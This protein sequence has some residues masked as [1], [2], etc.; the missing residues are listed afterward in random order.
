MVQPECS[1]L[2]DTLERSSCNPEIAII[3]L[4]SLHRILQL[5]VEQSL[6]SFKSLNAIARVL[7]VACIQAQELRKL[8][9]LSALAEDEFNEGSKFKRDWTASSVKTAEDWI[10]CMESSFEL[11]TEY[12]RIAENGKSLVLHNSNCIDC[13]F[14][15]FWEDNFRNLVLEQILGLFKVLAS[16]FLFFIN[17]S[18]CIFDN[19][20]LCLYKLLSVASIIRRRS[21]SKV[22]ALLQIS[23][24]IYPC[25]GKGKVFHGI[26]N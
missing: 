6:A 21:H 2:L 12:L 4:K 3:L 24:N 20:S 19:R 10:I 23:G 16:P 13:L 18:K 17:F 7:K 1:V 9:F 26:V 14:E 11:F 22:A 25:K 5:A 8:T 15:L